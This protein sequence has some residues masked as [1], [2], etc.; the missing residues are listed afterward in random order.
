MP[1]LRDA[2]QAPAPPPN[3]LS[4]S[5]WSSSPNITQQR[6]RPLPPPPLLLPPE[7]AGGAATAA[8]PPSARHH[9]PFFLPFFYRTYRYSFVPSLRKANMEFRESCTR[10]RRGFPLSGI[11]S[12]KTERPA[13]LIL[14]DCTTFHPN[15]QGLPYPLVAAASC[16]LP[17]SP[18]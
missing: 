16:P 17:P 14:S 8:S 15:H 11:S 12:T 6:T 10:K 3:P 9:N 4:L 1:L 5:S 13:L 7:E 2:V 18:R